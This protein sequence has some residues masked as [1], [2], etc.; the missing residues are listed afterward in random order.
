MPIEGADKKGF[1][2]P[3]LSGIKDFTSHVKESVKSYK[4]KP[5]KKAEGS[6]PVKEGTESAKYSG[7]PPTHGV[8]DRVAKLATP[9]G[10]G[11]KSEIQPEASTDFSPHISSNQK[12][13]K[14]DKRVE[15]TALTTAVK[16]LAGKDLDFNKKYRATI[17]AEINILKKTTKT[18]KISIKSVEKTI[19]TLERGARKKA[20]DHDIQKKIEDQKNHLRELRIKI[21]N[22]EAHLEELSKKIKTL[23]ENTEDAQNFF[24]NFLTSPRKLYHEARKGTEADAEKIHKKTDLELEWLAIDSPTGF[25][26]ELSDLRLKLKPLDFEQR[27]GQQLPVICI[28]SL[29]CKVKY[30]YENGQC[31]ESDLDLQDLKLTIKAGWSKA[32]HHFVVAKP[33]GVPKL[34][35]SLLRKIKNSKKNPLSEIWIKGQSVKAGLVGK[36][37][38]TFAK[39]KMLKEPNNSAPSEEILKPL[40]DLIFKQQ[41]FPM[42]VNCEQLIVHGDDTLPIDFHSSQLNAE[43]TNVELTPEKGCTP[44]LNIGTK[45][46]RITLTEAS[47]EASSLVRVLTKQNLLAEETSRQAG[48]LLQQLNGQQLSL[49]LHEPQA[50]LTQSLLP[51]TAKDHLDV[52]QPASQTGSRKA[53]LQIPQAVLA[54]DGQQKGKITLDNVHCQVHEHRDKTVTLRAGADSA[55]FQTDTHQLTLPGDVTLDGQVHAQLQKPGITLNRQKAQLR[56]AVSLA[57]ISADLPAPL[58]ISL[59]QTDITLDRLT[60]LTKTPSG[61]V[62]SLPELTIDSLEQHGPITLSDIKVEFQPELL[63]F[64]EK[65]QTHCPAIAIAKL[66]GTLTYPLTGGESISSDLDIGDLQLTF[67]A[68]WGETLSALREG[69]P[70]TKDLLNPTIKPEQLWVQ[71]QSFMVGLHKDAARAVAREIL[72]KSDTIIFDEISNILEENIASNWLFPVHVGCNTL[73]VQGDEDLPLTAQVDELKLDLTGVSPTSENLDCEPKLTFDAPHTKLELQQ[74]SELAKRMAKEL[75]K[76]E[77]LSALPGFSS[78]HKESILPEINSEELKIRLE[79]VHGELSQTLLPIRLSNSSHPKLHTGSRH[80]HVKVQKADLT[81]KGLSAGNLKAQGVEFLVEQD[82]KKNITFNVTSESGETR[83]HSVPLTLPGES[84]V[85]LSADRLSVQYQGL[86]LNL[87]RPADGAYLEADVT[88]KSVAANAK[89]LQTVVDS[90]NGAS[91][92][93]ELS[94][95]AGGTLFQCD[96]DKIVVSPELTLNGQNGAMIVKDGQPIPVDLQTAEVKDAAYIQYANQSPL[97]GMQNTTRVISGGEYLVKDTR[98]GP[99]TVSS[100]H[101][102]IDDNLSGPLNVDSAS[103]DLDQLLDIMDKEQSPRWYTRLFLKKK[104]L[105]CSLGC[106]VDQGAVDLKTMKIQKLK[107]SPLKGSSLLDRIVCKV[108]NWIV[109]PLAKRFCKFSTK[110]RAT[111]E[112]ERTT[113]PES[114]IPTLG[115][116]FG[117]FKTSFDLPAPPAV[118]DHHSGKLTI[119]GTLHEYGIQLIRFDYREQIT[120]Q[121]EQIRTGSQNTVLENLTSLLELSK[122]IEKLPD[123][124]GAITLMAQQWPSDSISTLLASGQIS[125]ELKDSLCNIIKLFSSHEGA[126][127]TALLMVNTLKPELTPEI[128]MQVISHFSPEHISDP[129]ALAMYFESTGHIEK[130]KSAYNELLIKAPDH[131]IANSRIG[132]LLMIE[133]EKNATSDLITTAMNYLLKGALNGSY[134]ARTVILALAHNTLPLISDYAHLY[135]AAWYLETEKSQEDFFTAIGHIESITPSTDAYLRAIT[136]LECRRRNAQM[137]IHTVSKEALKDL[138]IRIRAINAAEHEVEKLPALDA[139]NLGVI[140]LYGAGGAP[141]D[142]DKAIRLL[143]YANETTGYQNRAGLHLKICNPAFA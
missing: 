29:S 57:G 19:K 42:H 141:C 26:I 10:H 109:C 110:L 40:L 48:A 140:M 50:V 1:F 99:A 130:A 84:P 75:S 82:K 12:D 76:Q 134:H 96:K 28:K 118:L 31:I 133:A 51:E 52:T 55:D 138:R 80:A 98:V 112:K 13:K 7:E 66:N 58:T 74:G 89:G 4:G 117:P 16:L 27:D 47:K 105:T 11:K 78:D 71:S 73:R 100:L 101:L 115:I 103:V 68:S 9:P 69:R 56:S 63:S 85:T 81:N 62:L 119:A 79:S 14:E 106:P 49:D 137:I 94:V 53:T 64:R 132:S 39:S 122:V 124:A 54:T 37:V 88:A 123:N 120:A 91:F 25:P 23:K 18:T 24:I 45:R 8:T 107:F 129:L 72:L 60:A 143:Q 142:Q 116:K 87:M 43:L 104:M 22:H 46:S 86:G 113:H 128:F 15:A 121:L 36:S 77:T 102:S 90:K 97:S 5:L 125:A 30:F 17:K 6:S 34:L 67:K 114:H 93:N 108:M 21:K 92:P 61:Y 38:K 35:V 126:H 139:Y 127:T 20:N 41:M 135:A 70:I 3:L 44:R 65:D 59:G 111:T 33:R 2:Q 136:L 131:P 83:I 32:F 95:Q